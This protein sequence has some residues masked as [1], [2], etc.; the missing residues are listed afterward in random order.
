MNAADGFAAVQR[1]V[2]ENTVDAAELPED[3]LTNEANRDFGR[4]FLV[5]SC[6]WLPPEEI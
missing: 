1:S 2:S 5:R 3:Q 4:R 6:R